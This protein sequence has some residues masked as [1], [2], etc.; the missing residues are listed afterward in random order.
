[1]SDI[2][3]IEISLEDL[4]LARTAPVISLDRR[5]TDDDAKSWVQ[6]PEIGWGDNFDVFARGVAR[7]AVDPTSLGDGSFG[8]VAVEGFLRWGRAQSFIRDNTDFLSRFEENFTAV[9][10]FGMLQAVVTRY[11]REAQRTQDWDMADAKQALLEA[12][13]PH[14]DGFKAVWL[15]G[16]EETRESLST[17]ANLLYEAGYRKAD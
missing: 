3:A 10:V 16:A 2:K 15:R 4:E 14:P 12:A 7:Y 6:A 5:V 11:L 17:L 9:D 8:A 13:V 1:M